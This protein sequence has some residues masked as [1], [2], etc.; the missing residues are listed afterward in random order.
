M[1]YYLLA[2]ASEEER[3]TFHLKKP[4]EYHYLSQVGILVF[5]L[6][7]TSTSQT[8]STRVVVVVHICLCFYGYVGFVPCAAICLPKFIY[9]VTCSSLDSQE[10]RQLPLD[11]GKRPILAQRKRILLFIITYYTTIFHSRN[12]VNGC[13]FSEFCCGCTCCDWSS[14]TQQTHFYSLVT[15]LA[16][17]KTHSNRKGK[18]EM[19]FVPWWKWKAPCTE[20]TYISTLMEC[21]FCVKLGASSQFVPVTDTHARIDTYTHYRTFVHLS[22]L[23]PLC[24]LL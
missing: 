1:F 14:Y 18:T 11:T 2:G 22:S 4:E 12:N 16:L 21:G 20:H 15:T 9:R 13:W 10:A 6:L 8:C 5:H 23:F 17:T 24:L 19:P 3:T 7:T